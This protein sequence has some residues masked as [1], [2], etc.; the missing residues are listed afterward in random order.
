MFKNQNRANSNDW[1]SIGIFF[2]RFELETKKTKIY[3]I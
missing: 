1:Y 3:S 2:V